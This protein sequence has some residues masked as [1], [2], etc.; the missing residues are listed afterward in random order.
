MRPH[1]RRFLKVLV[2]PPLH[3]ININSLFASMPPHEEEEVLVVPVDEREEEKARL[4]DKPENVEA[5]DRFV[6][7]V[8]AVKDP[9]AL[10]IEDISSLATSTFNYKH[11]TKLN[12]PDCGLAELPEGFAEAF[13]NLSILF[14]SNNRFREMPAVVGK[15]PQLQMV[16]FKSNGMTIIHPDALQPQLRWCIL[17]NN[18]IQQLPETIGRCTRLQKLMLSGNQLSNLPDTM[19]NCT[20]LELIRLAANRLMEP[21]QV[22]LGLPNLA[23][24]GLS[25]NPFS[26]SASSSSALPTFSAELDHTEGQIL[27]QGAGGITRKIVTPDGMTV[28]LK[29]FCSN[30]MTSDGNPD[31]ERR[32]A[33]QTALLASQLPALVPVYGQTSQGSLVMEYLPAVKALAD[34]PSLVSCSRDV[35]REDAPSWNKSQAEHVITTLLETLIGLH[36]AGI[37]H[38]DFYSHNI[39]VHESDEDDALPQVRLTDFGAAYMYDRE[40][41]YATAIETTELRAFGVFVDEI[42]RHCVD[43]SSSALHELAEACRTKGATFDGVHIR[44][45]Q[46]QLKALARSFDPDSSE[47]VK[48]EKTTD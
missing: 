17:T 46:A 40:A 32:I 34:P 39:L 6:A 1:P 37:C 44:W 43:Q 12:L 36:R 19:E 20:S 25:D 23:W 2:V 48:E 27:G 3:S 11:V 24:M 31:S 45:R 26:W 4:D 14:L 9:N 22:L 29:Q 47:E 28:A 30:H 10:V 18:D 42:H 41:D 5:L 38:A 35:Y 16:A 13:P 7:N 15:C 33:T 21:P 8:V